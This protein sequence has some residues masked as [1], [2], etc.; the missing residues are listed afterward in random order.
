L[1]MKGGEGNK[2]DKRKKNPKNPAAKKEGSVGCIRRGRTEECQS[3]KAS[4]AI[5]KGPRTLRTLGSGLP[6]DITRTSKSNYAPKRD[7]SSELRRNAQDILVR[8]TRGRKSRR[9]WRETL[10]VLTNRAAKKKKKPSTMVGHGRSQRGSKGKWFPSG[11]SR[12]W[13]GKWAL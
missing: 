6:R 2:K 4:R 8:V 13:V 12:R 5:E 7:G 3:K 1:F 11:E 10:T 9:V